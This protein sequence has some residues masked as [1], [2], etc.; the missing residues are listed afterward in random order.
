MPPCF[1]HYASD[2]RS[3]SSGWEKHISK[4]TGSRAPSRDE[5]VK[6]AAERLREL[7]ASGVLLSEL[8]G[9]EAGAAFIREDCDGDFDV[10]A[11]AFALVHSPR[12]RHGED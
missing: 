9:D 1:C 7:Q 5:R 2:V 10:A 4:G 3:I 12:D 11:A 8:L 6:R